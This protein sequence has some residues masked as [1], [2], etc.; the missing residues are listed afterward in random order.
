MINVTIYKDKRGKSQGYHVSG[1]AGYDE[2]GKDIVCA[3][4]SVLAQTALISLF[5]VC[6]VDKEYIEYFIDDKGVLKV[7]VLKDL[8]SP[9]ADKVDVVFKTFEVGIK[10]IIESYPEHVSLKYKEV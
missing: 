1:H 5:E 10:A 4:V 8:S 2:Y 9:V 6:K 3:A 7:K